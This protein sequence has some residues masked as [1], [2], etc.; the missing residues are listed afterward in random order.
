MRKVDDPP[1]EKPQDRDTTIAAEKIEEDI[2]ENN[3]GVIDDSKRKRILLVEDNIVNQKLVL[4][5]LEKAGYHTDA[6][7]NGVEALKKMETAFY[8]LVLMDVQM[9]VKDGLEATRD[10]RQNEKIEGARRVPII[11][12]TAHA[13]KG[14]REKCLD[15]GATDYIPK[16]IDSQEFL[17]KV[18]YY[19]ESS[20]P[21]KS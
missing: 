21:V 12:I 19:T 20:E 15:A 2:R 4:K 1:P 18:K 5:I 3:A 11:A 6:V 10:I 14:D 8:D 7:F 13:M 9:P 17:K 16:P